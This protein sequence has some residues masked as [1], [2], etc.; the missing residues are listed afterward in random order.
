[1]LKTI[2]SIEYSK[3]ITTFFAHLFVVV[4]YGSFF[5]LIAKEYGTP[6][7]LSTT[8]QLLTIVIVTYVAYIEEIK[9]HYPFSKALG[10]N[11]L[12]F[13]LWLLV[14]MIKI[15]LLEIIAF[16]VVLFAIRYKCKKCV[17]YKRYNF[18]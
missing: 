17:E 8:I 10:V 6:Q 5:S 14:A 11:L 2:R 4:L 15:Y 18:G 13:I 3:L 7:W 16:I 1:M 12:G 9:R